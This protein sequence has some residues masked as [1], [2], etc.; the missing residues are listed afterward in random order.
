MSQAVIQLQPVSGDQQ[1]AT[2]EPAAPEIIKNSAF[3]PDIS[4]TNYRETQR[5]DGQTPA[6]R[7]REAL[8]QG[9]TEANRLLKD[10]R[11]TQQAAGCMALTDVEAE[12]IDGE[13]ELSVHYRRAVYS[14][15]RA[16]MTEQFR[17]TDTT[18]DGDR[19]AR[20]LEATTD[21]LWRQFQWSVND[22]QGLPHATVDLI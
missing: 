16:I 10:W 4:I 14:A 5:Q 17:G 15:A 1:L 18:T 21:D 7:L 2:A 13:S 9:M 11:L 20:A 19:R 12:I 8:L 3:W 6:V 22:V